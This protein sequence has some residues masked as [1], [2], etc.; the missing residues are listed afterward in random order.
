MESEQYKQHLLNNAHLIIEKAKEIAEEH[1]I[2]ITKIEWDSGTLI[3]DKDDFHTLTISGAGK[4]FQEKFF[5][6][7]IVDFPYECG[8]AIS[9]KIQEIIR[10]LKS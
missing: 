1:G 7:D 8:R 5:D 2:E 9:K 10:I 3:V 4:I 6:G